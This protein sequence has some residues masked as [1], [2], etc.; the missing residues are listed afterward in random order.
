MS[1]KNKSIVTL[2]I[3]VILLFINNFPSNVANASPKKATIP[4]NYVTL[5]GA[6]FI[7]DQGV[8]YSLTSSYIGSNDYGS[9]FYAPIIL[10]DGATLV[11]IIFNYM[12]QDTLGNVHAEVRR[13]RPGTGTSSTLG[14]VESDLYESSPTVQQMS[15][16]LNKPISHNYAYTLYLRLEYNCRLYGVRIVYTVP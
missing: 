3:I 12:D 9:D 4:L 15:L 8:N 1:G 11:K 7:P 5:P 6:S 2:S 10:P 13:V 14:M 16:N